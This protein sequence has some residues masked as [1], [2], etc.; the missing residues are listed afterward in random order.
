MRG[1]DLDAASLIRYLKPVVVGQDPL[2]R[3][4]LW[5]ALWQRNRSTTI[6][7]I[8]AVDVALWDLGGK[9]AGL[10]IHRLLGSY[11]ESLPAYA[12]SAVLGKPEEYAGH[13]RMHTGR[14]HQ[15]PGGGRQGHQQVRRRPPPVRHQTEA[16]QR[17]GG[18]SEVGGVELVGVEERD[19]RDPQ[20]V[21]DHGQREQ[22]RAQR[23]GQVRAD[24]GQHRQREGDV[25][26]RGDGP[27]AL[28]PVAGV[29]R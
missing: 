7:A 9:I 14:V 20:Q 8:G 19:D 16:E 1:A 11:R 10:P 18:G 6:R 5:Q 22:E 24:D 25:G 3:E 15:H 2:D 26:G 12:S 13:C 29:D 4:R 21:V 27:A 23:T 28:G 17:H